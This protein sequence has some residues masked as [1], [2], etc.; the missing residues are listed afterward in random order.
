MSS[1]KVIKREKLVDNITYFIDNK[2]IYLF[3]SKLDFSKGELKIIGNKILLLTQNNDISYININAKEI[4]E[5]KEYYQNLGFVLSYYDLNKLEYLFPNV[6]N[7]AL[8][9][10]Y[11]FI[12]KDDFLDKMKGIN[13]MKEK[14]ETKV[15]NSNSGFVSNMLLLF[16]GI[17]LLCYICIEGAIYLVK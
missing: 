7:K 15:I 10:C 11:A 14:K 3:L 16:G 9:R 1:K 6:K 4:L 13:N 5:R 12:R 2:T 17:I 8:Y